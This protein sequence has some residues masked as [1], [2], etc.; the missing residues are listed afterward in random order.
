[1]NRLYMWKAS[2]LRK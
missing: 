1:M 2:C